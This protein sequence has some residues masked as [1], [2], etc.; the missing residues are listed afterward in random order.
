MESRSPYYSV[1]R[2]W[3]PVQSRMATRRQPNLISCDSLGVEKDVLPAANPILGRIQMMEFSLKREKME[4]S[5]CDCSPLCCW[6]NR[7]SANS[8]VQLRDCA[9][10]LNPKLTALVSVCPHRIPASC[11]HVGRCGLCQTL[12][13]TNQRIGFSSP[14]S[15]H[16]QMKENYMNT[17]KNCSE[18]CFGSAKLN[19]VNGTTTLFI[20]P[21]WD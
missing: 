15:Q 20:L 10:T 12:S 19:R 2:S 3:Q 16:K 7:D 1:I 8:R 5:S 13:D 4:R 6:L 14:V 18:H 9:F 17:F 11:V 21:R